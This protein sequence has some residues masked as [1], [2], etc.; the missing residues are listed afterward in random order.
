[1]HK[2]VDMEKNGGDTSEK[3]IESVD[4][5]GFSDDDANILRKYEGAEGRRVVRKV[6]S[7]LL[8]YT[9]S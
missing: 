7:S 8:L 4:Y 6:L 3:F 9:K 5:P 1:M 2:M